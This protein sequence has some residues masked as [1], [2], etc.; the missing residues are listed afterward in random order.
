MKR[1]IMVLIII[2]AFGTVTWAQMGDM[3]RGGMHDISPIKYG[4]EKVSLPV[5]HQTRSR[6]ANHF[7]E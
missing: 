6:R 1:I 3:M 4:V 7:P 2:T 5:P